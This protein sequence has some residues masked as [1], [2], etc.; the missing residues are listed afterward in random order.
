VDAETVRRLTPSAEGLRRQFGAADSGNTVPDVFVLGSNLKLSVKYGSDRLA[1]HIS[2]E[3]VDIGNPYLPKEKVSAL[4]DELAPPA[5]RGRGGNGEFRSSACGGIG[6]ADYE[7]VL[8]ER[9]PN[10]C[11]AAHPDTEKRAI[12]Q[13]KRDVCPNPYIQKKAE[14]VNSR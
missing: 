6:M 2:I 11:A 13:F 1:C 4:L 10:Y 9:W 12:I 3:P 8:M 5:M 7:N 14:P